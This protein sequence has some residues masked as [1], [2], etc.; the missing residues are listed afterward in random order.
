MKTEAALV[1]DE[2]APQVK[3][4]ILG[5]N[6][7]GSYNPAN[8]AA[9]G[10]LIVGA[11]SYLRERVPVTFL[12]HY[13]LHWIF[14]PTAADHYT[15]CMVA[16]HRTEHNTYVAVN[17]IGL[18]TSDIVDA[19]VQYLTKSTLTMHTIKPQL[20][21]WMFKDIYLLSKVSCRDIV[22]IEPFKK[23]II[24]GQSKIFV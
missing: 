3:E 7:V 22:H 19:M 17:A 5:L 1:L 13:D 23:G 18:N 24:N 16:L 8:C 21:R 4:G 10:L 9:K 2:N 14:I 6:N 11:S 20:M 15:M 12:Q